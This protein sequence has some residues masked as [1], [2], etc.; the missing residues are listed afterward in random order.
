MDKLRIKSVK[1]ASPRAPSSGPGPAALSAAV[2][3]SA[4]SL[5]RRVGNQGMGRI[6]QAKLKIG[7][8]NDKYEREADRIAGRIM[9]MTPPAAPDEKP[10]PDA[11]LDGPVVQRK[12]AACE[13]EEQRIQLKPLNRNSRSDHS[14]NASV[15]AAIKQGQAL[16]GA[17]QQ[18]FGPRFGVDL[19]HVRLHHGPDANRSA[20]GLGARAYTFGHHIVFN[21]G[22]YRH[23]SPA[24]RVLLAHELTHVIQQS[25]QGGATLIQRTTTRGAGGCGPLRVVDEDL[26]G[27][28]A[29][30][31]TAHTQIQ[32]FLL[33]GRSRNI[34]SFNVFRIIS[35]ALSLL[36][37]S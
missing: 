6:I 10:G 25:K 34:I 36:Q 14:D 32:T 33:R 18:F 17:E 8:P 19:G 7:E 27:A 3:P 20:A 11:R 12:C 4:V 24:T 31:R 15:N 37:A 29:A 28:R 16:T 5:Q 9:E 23:D 1:D 30:G 13:E 22:E 35:C 26:D 21:R 2:S